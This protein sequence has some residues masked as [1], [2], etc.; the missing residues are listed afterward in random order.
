MKYSSSLRSNQV[1]FRFKMSWE[2][3]GCQNHLDFRIVNK[4]DWEAV[5]DKRDV[6]HK[7]LWGKKL[8]LSEIPNPLIAARGLNSYL[9]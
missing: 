9:H 5:E 1:R 6:I 4:R 3:T 8:I 2:K 7:C